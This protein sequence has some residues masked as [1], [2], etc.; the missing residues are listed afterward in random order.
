M[1]Q[2]WKFMMVRGRPDAVSRVHRRARGLVAGA[3]VAAVVGAGLAVPAGASADAAPGAPVISANAEP[4]AGTQSCPAPSVGAPSPA[5]GTV[6]SFTI[7]PNP[8]DVD[9][10]TG[11]EVTYPFNEGPE[12]VTAADPGNGDSFDPV[13][14]IATIT[15]VVDDPVGTLTVDTV[16]AGNVVGP[17]A[18][19]TVYAHY[20]VNTGT[21]QAFGDYDGD[22]TPDL[23]AAPLESGDALA[24][25][26][27]FAKGGAGG[28]VSADAR[29]LLINANLGTSGDGG[30]IDFTGAQTIPGDWCGT[31]ETSLLVYYPQAVAPTEDRGGGYVF[32]GDG[33]S[34]A[35]RNGANLIASETSIPSVALVDTNGVAPSELVDAGDLSQIDSG[36]PDVISVLDDELV[37]SPGEGAPGMYWT[38]GQNGTGL[39]DYGSCAELTGTPSPDG[40]FDWDAWK[41][42]GYPLADGRV[43]MYLWNPATGEMVLWTG[44]SAGDAAND[45]VWADFTTLTYTQYVIASGTGTSTWNPGANLE[46]QA[47]DFNG[48]GVPDLWAVNPATATAVPYTAK[49][50]GSTAKLAG[51]AKQSLATPAHEWELNDLTSGSANQALDSGA[52]TADPLRN[53]NAGAVWTADP[54]FGGAVRFDGAAGYLQTYVG[55][56]SS[57]AAVAAGSSFTVGA[58]VNPAGPGTVFAQEGT[59]DSSVFLAAAADGTWQFGI[60]TAGTTAATYAQ[61]DAGTWTSGSWAHVVLTYDAS[62]GYLVLYVNGVRAKTVRVTGAATVDGPFVLGADQVGGVLG[63]YLPGEVARVVTFGTALTAQEVR[64]LP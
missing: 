45:G 50:K 62:T 31:G 63:S 56:P 64:H 15:I 1:Y 28:S 26:V 4:P 17:A 48:D 25:G 35:V 52:D 59:D 6:C 60:N 41:V 34:D 18:S 24:N 51:G 23:V 37:L 54:T 30:P 47:A 46:F 22:G 21:S 29:N 12:F 2:G 49:I 38:D 11:Y 14:G 9:V 36:V 3:A 13:T 53:S 33:D 20:P 58:W 39:C 5:L 19:Q 42:V 61:G 57:G 10:P 55:A 40:T 44:V 27:W 43:D 32:C 16:D 7:S 8:A